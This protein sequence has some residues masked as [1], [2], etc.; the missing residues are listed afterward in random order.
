MFDFTGAHYDLGRSS[1]WTIDAAQSA[2]HTDNMNTALVKVRKSHITTS[3]V[4]VVKARS[5]G[6]TLIELLVV[7]AI[8]AIL[9]SL[10]LPALSKAKERAHRTVCKSNMRQ[11]C[12]A[13]IMYADENTDRY[14]VA[15]GHLAWIPYSM[16]QQFLTM[17]MTTN[18]LLCANYTKFKDELG[19]EA[20]YFDPP[21]NPNRVRLGFYALWGVNTIADLRPRD[22]SYG[23]T[24]APWDS[25]RKSSDRMTPHSVLMAD[26][27]EKGSGLTAT[28]YTRAPHTRNGM[29]STP[30]GTFPEPS[31]LGLQGANVAT[32]DGAVNWR[33]A[34]KMA[35]HTTHFSNPG[36]ATQA[37]FLDSSTIVGYW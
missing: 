11:L 29:A 20:V 17:K 4:A 19:N 1:L 25:P 26:L 15:A 16:Y 28:K 23:S 36:S 2:N 10:L 6:F 22:M 14:P 27:T 3:R 13:A 37:D 31:A 34:A 8:I 35:P 7:I 9:A 12:L 30:P 33:G 32:P 5:G 21:A 18:N 24:P